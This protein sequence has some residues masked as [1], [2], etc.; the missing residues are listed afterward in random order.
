MCSQ[1]VDASLGVLRRMWRGPDADR[2]C[3]EPGRPDGVGALG[4]SGVEH[5][6]C[7]CGGSVLLGGV[8]GEDDGKKAS[9]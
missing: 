8:Y 6:S 4:Q 7:L 3:G 1:Q 5:S 9:G 2:Q